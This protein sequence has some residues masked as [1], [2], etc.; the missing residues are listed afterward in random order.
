M[1]L[2]ITTTAAP[3]TDLGYLLYKN[4]DRIQSFDLAFGKAHVFY[5]EAT[6]ERC[7]AALLLDIDPIHLVRGQNRAFDQYVN[8]RP[9]V[10]SSF[11]SVA[12]AQVYGS[13]LSGQ[14]RERP[15][16]AERA[17][18]FT[19]KL[20]VIHSKDGDTTI[21]RLFEPLGYQVIVEK[22]LLDETHP[23]W[24][25]SNYYTVTLTATA[26]LTDLLSH[27]Y[28]LLPALDS[29]KHYWIGEDEVEKLL[30]HA[31]NWLPQHPEKDFITYRYLKHK[32]L[33]RAALSRLIDEDT[34]DPDQAEKQHE[35]EEA[36]IEQRISLHD[37]RLNA[38]LATLRN[39]G[40]RRILDLGC[41]EGRLLQLLLKEKSFEQITGM[42]I[43]YRT[44]EIAAERLKMEQMAPM[45]KERIQLL[46][47]SLT[48]KDKRLTGYDAAALVEVIEHLDAQR[49]G[50]LER[51]VFEFARPG[52]VVITTPN[53][54]Y[55]VKFETLPAG[56]MRHKDH[57]FE[58][59]RAEF[60]EWSSRVADRFNY[61][62]QFL[63]IG[64]EDPMVG[65]PTQMGV[66]SR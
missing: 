22:H 52:M 1:L 29:A 7:T 57:R 44:L 43:S 60:Q 59:T 17:L 54:E 37:Q 42:D 12:I 66:F 61:Q 30:R 8:D 24:G 45:Q 32:K 25:D 16:L 26:R 3:A 21:P 14:S 35:H 36:E 2:L 64:P 65:A 20:A 11:M 27:L 56:K 34:L 48:Y 40:G 23:E 49:L 33:I 50:V 15:E 38:V 53:S 47:G 41:G 31:K 5:P 9:Y 51:V 28:V 46:H 39:S 10:A 62:V 58:W 19:A 63:P 18:P 6:T 13:A 55:N 4:P